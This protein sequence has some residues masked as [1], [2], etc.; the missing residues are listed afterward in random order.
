MWK[1]SEVKTFTRLC[2]YKDVSRL[3]MFTVQI[4]SP[5]ELSSDVSLISCCSQD[6][7]Q[8]DRFTTSVLRPPCLH[9]AFFG[10]ACPCAT[11]APHLCWLYFLPASWSQTLLGCSVSSCDPLSPLSAVFPKN[12]NHHQTH[13]ALNCIHQLVASCWKNINSCIWL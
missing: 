7:G 12:I 1:S 6:W 5:S 9:L 13:S 2:I 3:Y 4:V 11:K 10:G 8:S